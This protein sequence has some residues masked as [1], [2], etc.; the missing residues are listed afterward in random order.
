L[1]LQSI[2]ADGR[3]CLHCSLN[4]SGFNE[5]PLGLR[6]VRPGYG[7]AVS[8]QLHSDLQTIRLGLAHRTLLLLHLWQQ[9]ELVLKM[10]AD[11]VSSHIGLRE[12]AGFA[13]DIASAETP[14]KV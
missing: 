2:V 7:Q 13:A 4:I 10:V 9:S 3:G 6:P 12:L 8:L 14:L 5:L 1:G 11:L